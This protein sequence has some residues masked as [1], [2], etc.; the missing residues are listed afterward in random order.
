EGVRIK[1][2][3]TTQCDQCGTAKTRR[4][5]RRT[6]RDRGSRPAQRLAIDFHDFEEGRGG[7]KYLMLVTDRYTGLVWDFYLENRT[8]KSIIN[9]LSYLLDVLK[10]TYDLKP[11]VIE[12]DNEI[13][14]QKP[15]VNQFIHSY[16]IKLEPSAPH[17]QSQ[18]GGAERSGGVI[19]EKIRAMRGKLPS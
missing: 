16:R 2:L 13:T 4:Q 15:Q 1:G 7:Y 6:P 18:N 10:Q 14:S 3:T 12:C 19:K 8:A 5:I 11:E 9:A 17:T